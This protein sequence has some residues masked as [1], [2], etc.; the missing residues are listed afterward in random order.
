MALDFNHKLNQALKN[1]SYSGEKQ[2][3]L[4]NSPEEVFSNNPKQIEKYGDVKWQIVDML[5]QKYSHLLKDKFD[6]Y[7]WLNHDESD[8]V[9]YFLNESGSNCLNHSEFKAPHKFHIWMGKNGFILGI[10]QK[11]RGFN[12]EE[13]H[14][15]EIK[16]NE[17]A[18][19]D[20]FRKCKSKI[21]FD[22]KNEAKMVF[23]EWKKD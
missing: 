14:N 10:E 19:F 6:L 1:I 8:E 15:H 5:N 21:F 4:V 23:M 18:A 11:G 3:L 2:E 20:F 22:D 12:A 9:A 17:G 7:N 13:I 16:E